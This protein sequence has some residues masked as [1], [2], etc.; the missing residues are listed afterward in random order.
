MMLSDATESNAQ[1]NKLIL[2]VTASSGI[3]HFRKTHLKRHE[4]VMYF[5]ILLVV[6]FSRKNEKPVAYLT[7]TPCTLKFCVN[8]G[9]CSVD[10]HS[11]EGN[12]G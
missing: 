6:C 12:P 3:S 2:Q 9:I 11:L 1:R 7:I 10:T 4:V 8:H 5:T